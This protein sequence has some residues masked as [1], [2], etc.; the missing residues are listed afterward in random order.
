MFLPTL[1]RPAEEQQVLRGR[2]Y[3][4][5]R[6]TAD[7]WLDDLAVFEHVVNRGRGRHLPPPD[8]ELV[9]LFL[10]QPLRRA[11]RDRQHLHEVRRAG[12]GVV[13]QAVLRHARFI[14]ADHRRPRHPAPVAEPRQQ[15]LADQQARRDHH[16]DPMHAVVPIEPVDDPRVEL[17][18]LH[19]ERRQHVRLWHHI[20]VGTL[21]VGQD[22]RERLDLVFRHGHRA[23]E[24]RPHQAAG[25]PQ[26][27][28]TGEVRLARDVRDRAN[29]RQHQHAHY[30]SLSQG[31][32]PTLLRLGT[33][34]R[35]AA[36]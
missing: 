11:R 6:H 21:R 24:L 2:F 36:P 18:L 26:R 33:P 16:V 20:D 27:P 5:V 13:R 19:V 14:Q 25:L 8:Q 29:Q 17:P 35:V 34:E 3:R 30:G 12:D 4:I 28:E 10:R 9:E 23:P 22:L 15:L 31:M 1:N 32:G 7:D